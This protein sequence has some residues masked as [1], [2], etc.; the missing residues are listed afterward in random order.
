MLIFLAGV[1]F[2]LMLLAV[3][4]R[5]GAQLWHGGTHRFFDYCATC[6]VRFGRPAGIA[7]LICPHGHVMSAVIAEPHTPPARGITLIGVC[8]GFIAV[9]LVLTL[10]GVVHAP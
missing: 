9:A 7:R 5:A 6:D 4:D 2:L 1:A 10:T 8:A 3:G